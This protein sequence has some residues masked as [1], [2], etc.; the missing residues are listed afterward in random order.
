MISGCAG[1]LFDI[2]GTLVESDPLHLEAFNRAFCPMGIGSI[3]NGSG[4]N[5]RGSPMRR[6]GLS[7]CRRKPRSGNGKS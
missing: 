1:L 3:A 6:S 2:D 7:F 5:C 4:G